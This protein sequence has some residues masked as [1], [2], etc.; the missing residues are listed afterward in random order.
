MTATTAPIAGS[1]D[2][3]ILLLVSGLLLRVI[4]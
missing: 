2:R 1:G 4:T 3:R